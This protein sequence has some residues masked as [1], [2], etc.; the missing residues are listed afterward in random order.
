MSISYCDPL[1]FRRCAMCGEARVPLRRVPL[2]KCTCAGSSAVFIMEGDFNLQDGTGE[3]SIEVSGEAHLRRMFGILPSECVSKQRIF[4]CSFFYAIQVAHPLPCSETEMKYLM[5]QAAHHP[6]ARIIIKVLAGK[7]EISDDLGATDFYIYIFWTLMKC[8]E[9]P[10]Y[11]YFC[12]SIPR[13]LGSSL[14]SNRA[15]GRL[16]QLPRLN[17]LLHRCA[18]SLRPLIFYASAKPSWNTQ[19][20]VREFKLKSVRFSTPAPQRFVLTN[21]YRFAEVSPCRIRL[22]LLSFEEVAPRAELRD[23]LGLIKKD[24]QIRSEAGDGLICSD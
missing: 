18:D 5:E 19:P 16:L 24:M 2:S 23:L 10:L 11:W 9:V 8:C 4:S 12:H 13:G 20:R 1:P 21:H 17:M 7:I 14:P 15:I 3:A 6:Q 22:E